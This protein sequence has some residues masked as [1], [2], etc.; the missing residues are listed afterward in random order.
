MMLLIMQTIHYSN[1]SH[2]GRRVLP[3]ELEFVQIPVR[4]GKNG[5]HL[6]YLRQVMHMLVTKLSRLAAH[7]QPRNWNSSILV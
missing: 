7:F 2:G 3:D 6:P 4:C 5:K 1:F